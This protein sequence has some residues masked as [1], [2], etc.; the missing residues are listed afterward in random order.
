MTTALLFKKSGSGEF[1]DTQE[2][3]LE[4]T[5]DFSRIRCP[6]CRWQ[7]KPHHRWFCTDMGHPEY[8][9]AGCGTSWNTFTTRGLCPGCRHQWRYTS[10][11]RCGQMSLHDD[12]Y[13]HT[14]GQR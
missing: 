4:D 6:Q 2:K 9:F 11:I 14:D 12:W 8:F 3:P 13:V 10:C 7:P 5:A 1:I